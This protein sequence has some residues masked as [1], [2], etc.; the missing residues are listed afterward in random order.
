M[1][2]IRLAARAIPIAAAA[3][4]LLITSPTFAVYQFHK[5]IDSTNDSSVDQVQDFAFAGTTVAIGYFD[6]ID[7]IT[8][9]RTLGTCSPV[10]AA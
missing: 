4:T 9:A 10:I 1:L 5:I 3:F 7:A 6:K 2:T 8:A